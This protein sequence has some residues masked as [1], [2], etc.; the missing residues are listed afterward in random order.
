MVNKEELRLGQM[1]RYGR[2]KVGA[3]VDAL[4]QDSCGLVLDGGRYELAKYGDV[5]YEEE[6]PG[7]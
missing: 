6:E 5:Y 2:R 3:K 4:T 7:R 1:V